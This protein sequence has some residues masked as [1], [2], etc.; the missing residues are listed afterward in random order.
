MLRKCHLNTCSVGV[1]TQDPELRRRFAGNPDHVVNFFLLLA[2]DIRGHMARLGFR[3]LDDMIGR[4][5]MLRPR[6]R[7]DHWKGR[8]VDLS[9][10]LAQPRALPHWPRRF[11]RPEP[12]NLDNHIDR[13]LMPRLED[14][15][16]HGRPVE[17]SSAIDNTCRAAGTLLSGLIARTH[18]ARGLADETIHIRFQGSAGQSFG[19][20]LAAGV[21][22]ELE[23]DAN[24]YLGKGLSGGR[25][26]VYPPRASRFK[27]E[28][29][30][31]VGNTLLYGA[32][33]GEVYING[34]AGERFAVR[35]SGARA[36]VEGVGDHGC[37]YMT[38]GVVVVLGATG[39]NFAAGM[40][41]GVAYVFDKEHGFRKRCNTGMVELE[42]LVE[43]SEIWL[44]YGMIEDH[45]RYTGSKLGSHVL[46]NWENLISHFVKVMPTDY[47][48]VLQARRAARRPSVTAPH[49]AVVDGGRS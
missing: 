5:D 1:A 29:N 16:A 28:E 38:G 3:H 32:T 6:R 7:V 45:V 44:V 30:I 23:G 41:G 25:I 46:D 42:A 49:L 43:E 13:R 10:I 48:R 34:L 35:N 26:M 47:K 4:V 31:L 15:I 11:V 8:K 37:E 36:V 20:F 24:D 12:W 40:S 9:A 22:L 18:G 39:R 14:A 17:I 19:A 33:A 2:E 27:A 21:T